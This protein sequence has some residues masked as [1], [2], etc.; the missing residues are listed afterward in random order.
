[1]ASRSLSPGLG[2]KPEPSGNGFTRSFFTQRAAGFALTAPAGCMRT[3]ISCEAGNS[4]HLDSQDS[5]AIRARRRTHRGSGG[6]QPRTMAGDE[7]F[8]LRGWPPDPR[9]CWFS[10][11]D[12]AVND[13]QR[14]HQRPDRLPT[15]CAAAGVPVP[16]DR[17]LDGM[18]IT[19]ALQG[20]HVD[21]NSSQNFDETG[22][23]LWFISL[24]PCRPPSYLHGI[25]RSVHRSHQIASSARV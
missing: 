2:K 4:A 7:P 12:Q 24:K 8:C 6:S 25:R 14:A 11:Q 16:D 9:H 21:R 5:R 22:S 13:R 1:M 23:N 18:D 20:R 10:R 19:R 15:V 3:S 17:T